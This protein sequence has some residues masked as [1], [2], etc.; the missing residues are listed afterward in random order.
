LTEEA[1]YRE[2]SGLAS[3][4]SRRFRMGWTRGTAHPAAKGISTV[5]YRGRGDRVVDGLENGQ[6]PGQAAYLA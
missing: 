6:S 1:G 5:A 2:G 4:F 3:A